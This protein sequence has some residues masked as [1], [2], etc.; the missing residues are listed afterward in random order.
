MHYIIYKT[1]NLINGKF[2][3]GK[4]QTKNLN[5]GYIGSGKLL[6][7]AISKYGLDQFKTEIIE[8]CPTEAHMNL[9]ERIYV[10]IDSEVSYNLCSGGRGGFGYINENGLNHNNKDLSV[11]RRKLSEST[12]RYFENPLHVRAYSERLQEQHRLGL[13][14]KIKC[15]FQGKH[16]SQET[17]DKLKRSKN[18]GR[19][20]PNYGKPRSE[21]TKRKIRESHLKRIL[22]AGGLAIASVS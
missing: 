20:N 3:I 8:M 11:I 2:Y 18:V 5:D 16:H 22:R 9:A 1:T 6:K 19:D 15:S 17:I 21:E 7:R 13:R 14:P 4:H 10:V 12:K